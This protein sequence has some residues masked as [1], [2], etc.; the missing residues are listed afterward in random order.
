[1]CAVPTHSPPEFA[2]LSVA[3]RSRY[4]CRR[5]NTGKSASTGE[6]RAVCAGR[7]FFP[8]HSIG[9]AQSGTPS[10]REIRAAAYYLLRETDA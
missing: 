10:R 9:L 8:F 3:G 5:R 1:M 6:T 4:L 7:R 2:L